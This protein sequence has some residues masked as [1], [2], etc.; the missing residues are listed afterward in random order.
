[1]ELFFHSFFLVFWFGVLDVS[2]INALF[3][4]FCFPF[5][6]VLALQSG[7]LLRVSR[8]LDGCDGEQWIL[9]DKCNDL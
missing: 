5:P 2:D 1:M 8:G 4:L 7:V 3:F 6:F 9:H